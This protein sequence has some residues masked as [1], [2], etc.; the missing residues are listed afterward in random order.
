MQR[1]ILICALLG[2]LSCGDAR[3][4]ETNGRIV[5]R[6][7]IGNGQIE[8]SYIFKI[9]QTTVAGSKRIENKSIPF[10]SVRIRYNKDNPLDNRLILVEE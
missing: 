10:D 6:K 7:D 4:T 2:L 8:L 1:L 5:E 3:Y 9:G